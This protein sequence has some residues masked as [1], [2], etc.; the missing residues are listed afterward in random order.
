MKRFLKDNKGSMTLEATLVFPSLFLFIL[1]TTF[2]CII[3][4]QMGMAKYAAYQV[5]N[6]VAFNYSSSKKDENG[7]LASPEYLTGNSAGDGLYWRLGEGMSEV[8]GQFGFSGGSNLEGQKFSPYA[9]QSYKSI[10]IDNISSTGTVFLYKKIDVETSIGIYIPEF[11]QNISGAEKVK[12]KSSSIVTDTPELVREYNFIK[13]LLS[14]LD[15]KLTGTP[16][17]DTVKEWL[18]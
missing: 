5:S 3:V 11:A 10:S 8:L 14:F 18:P 1:L 12:G 6:T 9:G 4:F 17:T 15:V 2:V 16:I 13:F 7:M